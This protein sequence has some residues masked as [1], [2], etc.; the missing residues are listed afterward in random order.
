MAGKK[1]HK[2]REQGE[3]G[4]HGIHTQG[5]GGRKSTGQ[6]A[7]QFERDPKNRKG[8]FSGAGDPPLMKK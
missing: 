5:P 1:A 4:T 6:T 8:Q 2:P 7:G 3:A